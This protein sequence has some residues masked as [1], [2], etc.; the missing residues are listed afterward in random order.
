M[1]SS[2]PP[3]KVRFHLLQITVRRPF[4]EQLIFSMTVLQDSNRAYLTYS[5]FR[6]HITRRTITHA[7]IDKRR[8]FI[9]LFDLSLQSRC[10]IGSNCFSYKRIAGI[11]PDVTWQQQHSSRVQQPAPSDTLPRIGVRWLWRW[12]NHTQHTFIYFQPLATLWKHSK[13]K[14]SL[15]PTQHLFC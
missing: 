14:L 13:K 12:R 3:W 5:A 7:R 6:E 1:A 10:E 8:R 11:V 4:S 9:A 2:R 15:I